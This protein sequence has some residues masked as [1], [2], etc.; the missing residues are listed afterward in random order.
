MAPRKWWPLACIALWC[1]I[2]IIIIIIIGAWFLKEKLLFVSSCQSLGVTE[3]HTE[4]K[5]KLFISALS[6]DG[7]Y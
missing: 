7:L 6:L 1:I 4:T 3:K 2:I 5:K